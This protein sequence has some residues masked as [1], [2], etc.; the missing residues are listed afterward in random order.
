[1]YLIIA[2]HLRLHQ[3]CTNLSKLK[4]ENMR[5]NF[6]F[7]HGDPAELKAIF[8]L[9]IFPSFPIILFGNF[10]FYPA[11]FLFSCNLFAILTTI[12]QVALPQAKAHHVITVLPSSLL[13]WGQ[14]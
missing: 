9:N 5:L 6:I 3:S 13:F 12:S 4:F 14:I 1:M 11:S 7:L 8:Y 2:T 10:S